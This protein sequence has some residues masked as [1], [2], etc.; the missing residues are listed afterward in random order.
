M[1]WADAEVMPDMDIG[2]PSNSSVLDMEGLDVKR[3][4]EDLRTVLIE[5]AVGTVRPKVVN[6]MPKGGVY[7]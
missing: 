3:L 5:K 4:D 2:W 6:G 1:Q 7:V